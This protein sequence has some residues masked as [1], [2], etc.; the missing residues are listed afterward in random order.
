MTDFKA[1]RWAME[2]LGMKGTVAIKKTSGI[3]LRHCC[4]TCCN[5]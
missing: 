2:H 3:T 5:K 4:E 1:K